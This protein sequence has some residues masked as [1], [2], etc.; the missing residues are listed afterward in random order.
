MVQ[1]CGGSGWTIGAV[2]GAFSSVLRVLS[3]M[4]MLRGNAHL[5]HELARP[6]RLG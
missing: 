4:V 1:R 3:S 5:R 6:K 2:K